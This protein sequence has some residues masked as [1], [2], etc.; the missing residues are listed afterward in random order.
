MLKSV[1]I[2][3]GRIPH[4]FGQR[5][6]EVVYFF[7][8]GFSKNKWKEKSDMETFGRRLR[9][10]YSRYVWHV[11]FPDIWLFRGKFWLEWLASWRTNWPFLCE[12][13]RGGVVQRGYVENVLNSLT[14]SF[15]LFSCEWASKGMWILFWKV[16]SL[17]ILRVI[18]YFQIFRKK[19]FVCN[20]NLFPR[21]W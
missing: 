17:M 15:K 10:F 11:L 4:Q 20:Y 14:K 18:K 6:N 8:G 21:E 19:C 3:F 16:A 9:S 12:G 2:I 7:R 5:L 1:R 13:L